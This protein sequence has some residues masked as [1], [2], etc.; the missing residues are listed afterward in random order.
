LRY[1]YDRDSNRLYRENVVNELFSDLYHAN[2][3]SNGYDGLNQ[4]TAFSRGQLSD[5]NGDGVPDTVSSPSHSQSWSLDALGNWTSVTTDGSASSRT[6]NQQNEATAVGGAALTYDANGNLTQDQTGKHLVYDA[7]NRLVQVKDSSGNPLISYSYDA[8]GR[9]VTENRSGTITDLY[10]SSE[11]Q[12]LEER[13]GGVARAQY[14]WNPVNVDTLVL[15]DR[16]PSGSGT[17]SE[18]LYAQHDANNNVTALVD[19]NGNVVERYD[20][21]PYGQA[22]VLTP[23]WATQAGGSYGW[24]YLHQG[25]RYEGLSGLYSF[26]NRDFSPTLG[27]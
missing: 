25:G 16:D 26:R 6:H 20:Y 24:V 2:G 13:V 10:Y 17:L 8:L 4:L 1:G 9:R 18:R 21:D 12:V 7:W 23:T 11:W 3:A 14:V 27:R 15:R 19:V 22:T 5:T